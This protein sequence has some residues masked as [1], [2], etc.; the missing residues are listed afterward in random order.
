VITFGVMEGAKLWL[1]TTGCQLPI[2][3][4]QD[5]KL[6]KALGLK[7]SVAKVIPGTY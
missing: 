2:Y 4:D 1:E 5:R 7:R 6:Y 3:A